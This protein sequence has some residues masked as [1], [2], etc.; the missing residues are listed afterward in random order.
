[1]KRVGFLVAAVF[2]VWIGPAKAQLG[3][4]QLDAPFDGAVKRLARTSSDTF[5]VEQDGFAACRGFVFSDR[6]MAV[7]GAQT[8]SDGESLQVT[9]IRVRADRQQYSLDTVAGLMK[10]YESL[11]SAYYGRPVTECHDLAVVDGD[12]GLHES[13][14]VDVDECTVDDEVNTFVGHCLSHLLGRQ[15]AMEA[16]F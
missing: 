7:C 11:F 12:R 8:G 6:R 3:G 15:Y 5:E 14:R 9:W 10:S 4:V 13:A 2:L 16:G 1:M